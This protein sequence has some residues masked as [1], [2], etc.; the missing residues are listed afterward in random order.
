MQRRYDRNSH[1]PPPPFFHLLDSSPIHSNYNDFPPSDSDPITLSPHPHLNND[2]LISSI[3]NDIQDHPRNE[4]TP[5]CNIINQPTHQS[6]LQQDDI[7]I[8]DSNLDINKE[9][10]KTFTQKWSQIFT[11]DLSWNDFCNKCSTF[12]KDARLFAIELSSNP[13]RKPP[14]PSNDHVHVDRPPHGR[15]FQPF[16]N[17]DAQKIQSLY[18]H[19]KKRAARKILADNSPTYTGSLYDAESFFR[20]SFAYKPCD[21]D[22]LKKS[23]DSYVPSIEIDDSLFYPP[24][25]EEICSKVKSATNTSPGPD[26]IEYRHLKKIDPDGT[27]L[28]LIFNRCFLEKNVPSSWKSATTILIHK[29]NSND[30]PSN[31]R[32]IALMSCIYKLLVGIIA[33]R[34]TSWAISNDLLS[35]EQKSARPSEGCYEHTFLLQSIIADARRLQKNIFLAWLDLKNAFGSIPHAAISTTLSHM[36]V[37]SSLIDLIMNAYS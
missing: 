21:I 6:F 9:K 17:K 31:F 36:G 4:E 32:P 19:S 10:L 5:N 30:D 15:Q 24:S 3:E 26:K 14:P 23:L 34:L 22:A 27:I 8:E 29:K 7:N 35:N 11:S 13:A 1:S 28:S 33:K 25:K 2:H 18:N 16:N 20:N 37:P 12:T